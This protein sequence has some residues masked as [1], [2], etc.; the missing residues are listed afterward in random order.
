MNHIK[1]PHNSSLKLVA[2]DL[3]GVECILAGVRSHVD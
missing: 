3:G 2:G 1:L